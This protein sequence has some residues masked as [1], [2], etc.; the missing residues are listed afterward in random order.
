[1]DTAPDVTPVVLDVV[2]AAL[3]P[4]APSSAFSEAPA[5]SAGESNP[6]PDPLRHHHNEGDAQLGL[7]ALPRWGW[8]ATH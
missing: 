6:W 4:A 1:M 8:P 2:I 3:C 5:A 7:L